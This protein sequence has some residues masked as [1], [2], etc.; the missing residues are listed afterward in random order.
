LVIAQLQQN[1]AQVLA[2]LGDKLTLGEGFTWDEVSAALSV[3]QA[4]IAEKTKSKV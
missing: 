3:L 1:D 2:L 4:E